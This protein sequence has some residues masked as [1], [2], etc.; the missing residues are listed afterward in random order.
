MNVL[1]LNGSPHPQEAKQKKP[2]DPDHGPEAV[3][4]H[5]TDADHQFTERSAVGARIRILPACHRITP[6]YG[7]T[8]QSVFLQ[9]HILFSIAHLRQKCKM[10]EM[11]PAGCTISHLGRVDTKIMCRFLS[12]ISAQTRRGNAAGLSPSKFSRRS[13]RKI[14]PKRCVL[15]LVSTHPN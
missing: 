15:G 4:Y 11:I 9:S 1:I 7:N 2:Q 12:R 13:M 8:C 5:H 14:L 3:Q 10:P 6:F